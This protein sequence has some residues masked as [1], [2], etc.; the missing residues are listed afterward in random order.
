MS[1]ILKKKNDTTSSAIQKDLFKDTYRIMLLGELSRVGAGFIDALIVSN[2]LGSSAIAAVGIVHPYFSIVGVFSGM[3]AIGTQKLCV[4]FLGKGDKKKAEDVLSTAVTAALV[5]AVLLTLLLLCFSGSIVMILGAR[6]DAAN[7]HA[8]G[9]QYLIGLAVGT[10][11]MIMTSLLSPIAQA[12]GK[13]KNIKAALP[14]IAIFDVLFDLL[15]V[16]TKAAI[17]GMGLATSISEWI[18][19]LIIVSALVR[20]PLLKV[21]LGQVKKDYL[22]DIFKIGTPKLV[23]RVCNTI[24]PILLNSL[25]IALGGSIAMSA[26]SIRNSIGN[27]VE[28]FG[29]GLSSAALLL[30]SLYVGEKNKDALLTLRKICMRAIM[31]M[32]MAG[33]VCIALFAKTIVGFYIKD[34]PAVFPYA[35]MAV[36][37]VAINLPLTA[38]VEVLLGYGQAIGYLKQANFVSVLNRLVYLVGP[39]AI[40]G[41][42]FGINGIWIAFPAGSVLTIVT[43]GIMMFM[44]RR[45]VSMEVLFPIPKDCDVPDDM[46]I[47][48]TIHTLEQ[49]S[50]MSED[51]QHF[52]LDRGIEQ[53]RSMFVA[54]CLEEMAANI[55]EHGFT[56]GKGHYSVDIFVAVMNGDIVL[57]LRDNC[58]MF[59]VVEKYKCW[60][61]DPEHPEKGIGIHMVMKMAKNVE[62]INTFGTNNLIVTV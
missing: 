50:S 43:Y 62:Y 45:R 22:W 51:I 11:A 8:A 33:A 19:L 7:L 18:G 26:M 58:D 52:C 39:A 31:T 10:P 27:F 40:L 5:T 49:V 55:V 15:A 47:V 30:A 60:Q 38:I 54:L 2:F 57:R 46:K 12:E 16:K 32:I 44:K 20:K 61:Y 23:R 42:I 25:V 37:C 28:C 17:F 3:I 4:G 13:K 1:D 41:Y 56:R 48:R 29:M 24:R 6:G 36:R 14:A 35:V 59:D 53:R 34:D 21:S 9:R